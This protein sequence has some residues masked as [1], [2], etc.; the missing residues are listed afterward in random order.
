[1]EEKN[2]AMLH[3]EEEERKYTVEREK[4]RKLRKAPVPYGYEYIVF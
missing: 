3:R 2:K 4:E 1:M